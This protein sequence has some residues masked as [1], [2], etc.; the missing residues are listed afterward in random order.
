MFY[1]NLEMIH[2]LAAE[3][4]QKPLIIENVVI[5]VPTQPS[6]WLKKCAAMLR[7]L[8]EFPNS[9]RSRTLKTV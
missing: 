9:L 4:R 3:K 6:M 5:E 1:A 2:V 8:A 7:E